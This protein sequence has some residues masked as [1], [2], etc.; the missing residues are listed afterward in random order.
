[1]TD[2]FTDVIALL[3]CRCLS[4]D[5]GREFANKV[6][7]EVVRQWPICRIV[8]GKPRHS[9]SQGSVERAN[10]DIGDILI[11]KPS[12]S[13]FV[14]KENVPDKEISLRTAVGA[15]SLSGGQGHKHCNCL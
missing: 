5:N 14:S 2:N 1:M 10:R 11:M 4:S 7:S 6:V 12:S 15:D 9:Q 8:H 13:Q 3:I